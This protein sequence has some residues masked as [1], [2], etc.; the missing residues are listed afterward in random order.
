MAGW[1]PW[2]LPALLESSC[3]TFPFGWWRVNDLWRINILSLTQYNP[4]CYSMFNQGSWDQIQVKQSFSPAQQQKQQQLREDPLAAAVAAEV[5]LS[6]ILTEL[7]GSWP[8]GFL[9]INQ[10]WHYTVLSYIKGTGGGENAE[11]FLGLGFLCYVTHVMTTAIGALCPAKVK[12]METPHTLFIFLHLS[13][14]L[15]CRVTDLLSH[16]CSII[17]ALY[18]Q[19]LRF[20][21]L[22]GHTVWWRLI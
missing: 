4:D 5:S 1:P 20:L 9:G 13:L 2:A 10:A 11:W 7:Q 12:L 15:P 17:L 16:T 18:L 19:H 3:W 14:S 21:L 6:E 8:W 22:W